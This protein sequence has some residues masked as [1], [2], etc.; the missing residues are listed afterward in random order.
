MNIEYTRLLGEYIGNL[1]GILT[2]DIP[3]ELKDN[4][5]LKIKKLKSKYGKRPD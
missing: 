2:W 4:I 5:E 3:K 1:Q